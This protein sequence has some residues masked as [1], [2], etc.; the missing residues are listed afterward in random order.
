M[1][2]ISNT[3]CENGHFSCNLKIKSGH[4]TMYLQHTTRES[5]VQSTQTARMRL[6]PGG[7]ESPR[8]R[9][10]HNDI[11]RLAGRVSLSRSSRYISIHNV[12]CSYVPRYSLYTLSHAA[13]LY[14]GKKGVSMTV[15]CIHTNAYCCTV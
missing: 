8:F 1:Y 7:G 3:I 12:F 15:K 4:P 14:Y 10:Y 9:N 6:L 13:C 5:T 2:Y 11:F